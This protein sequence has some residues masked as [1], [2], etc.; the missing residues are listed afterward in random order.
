MNASRD[1]QVQVG[2][3]KMNATKETS[4]VQVGY[5]KQMQLKKQKVWCR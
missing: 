1:Q 3:S 5:N 2:Y 4:V